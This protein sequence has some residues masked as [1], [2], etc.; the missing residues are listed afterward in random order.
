M[1]TATTVPVDQA[2]DLAHRLDRIE[3]QL[4]RVSDQLEATALERDRW[5]ELDRKSVV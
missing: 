1:S 5:R 3:A 4:V 2:V